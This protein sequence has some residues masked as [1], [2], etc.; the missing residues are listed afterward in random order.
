[1]RRPLSIIFLLFT[2]IVFAQTPGENIVEVKAVGS[3]F[4]FV[5]R[6]TQLPV[7]QQLWDETD[8]FANG[9]ARVFL[10]N[11]FTFVNSAGIP[12]APAEFE[13]ARNFN[14]K[15]AAVKKSDK[16][17][18]I[19]ESGKTVLPFQY[20]IVFD[21]ES[22]VTAVYNNRKWWL[23]NKRGEVIKPLDITVCYGFRNGQA[24]VT[25]DDREGILYPDGRIVLGPVKNNVIKPIPYHPNTSN[26]GAPCP[27][28]I[29]FENGNFTN[30]QCFLGTVDSVGTTNVITVN[31][32]APT[33]NRHTIVPRVIPSA[34]DPFGLFPTN[35][36]DGSNFA[37]KLG[38]TSVGAQAERIRYTI[39]VPVNDSNFSI[40]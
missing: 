39:H 12:V 14:G 18:F 36:P 19:N 10:N 40:K 35:P 5:N 2:S 31:P 13:D 4:Q 25:K 7:S 28:N 16:W 26:I 8:P 29:D 23:V 30:W 1:M 37:V 38:N 17:G 20:E 24:K 32:S 11:K 21:F 22:P 15:L 34:L 9:F 6:Q 33:V 27:P 3:K